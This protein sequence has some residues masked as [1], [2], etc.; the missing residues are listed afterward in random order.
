[1][2]KW[3]AVLILFAI[4]LKAQEDFEDDENDL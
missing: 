4:K 2:K 3:L 1:M